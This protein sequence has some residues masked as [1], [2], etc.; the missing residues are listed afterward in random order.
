MKLPNHIA[1]IMDGNGRWAQQRSR[2]RSLGHV[3]GTRVA[4]KIITEC[5]RL[6][7]KWLT[8]YAFSAENWLR[9]QGEVDILM[10]IL[11]RYLDRETENL[12][13]ENIRLSIVGEIERLSPALRQTLANSMEATKACTGLHL[14]FALSYGSRQ[15]ITD[16][17]RRLASEVKAGRLDPQEIDEA[18]IHNA[19]W[20]SGM[21]DPDFVIRTSGEQRLSNFLLWQ[22]AYAELYFTETL[23]PDFDVT[24]LHKAIQDFKLR[25]RRY[26]RVESSD[27]L[28]SPASH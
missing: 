18:T 10:K 24:H 14:V 6:G 2:P 5:S 21:P 7:I 17:V 25:S 8:M 9:P 27:E 13:R 22:T 3:K 28:P 4:K 15:E 11:K 26:G 23:W 1:I 12:V 20:T 16:S 19:L